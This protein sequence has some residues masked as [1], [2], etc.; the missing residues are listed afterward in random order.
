MAIYGCKHP[1]YA[2]IT[3]YT[4]GTAPVYGD[5]INGVDKA[6]RITKVDITIDRTD[7]SLAGDNVISERDNSVIGGSVTSGTTHITDEVKEKV[8]GFLKKGTGFA[9]SDA[10]APFVGYGCVINEIVEGVKSYLGVWV[11]RIQ[12][13]GGNMSAETKGDS[14]NFQT[15]EMSGKMTE[16]EIGTEKLFLLTE[17]FTTEDAAIAWVDNK[18]AASA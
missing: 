13:A 4:A 5:V 10:S 12:F 1:V 8:L 15:S 16:V 3:S 9:I 11:Y 14:I 17:S 6:G 7:A 2:P 18:G